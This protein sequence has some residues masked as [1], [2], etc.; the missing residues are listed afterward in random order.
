MICQTK[1]LGE[2]CEIE[3]GRTPSRGNKKYWDIERQTNNVWLSIADL[4]NVNDKI[5]S[6]SKE[7]I[8]DK[9]AEVSKIVRKGT[10]LASF[11]LTLGRLAFAGKDLYTNEAIAA[12]T[13][14]NEK[15]ISKDYLYHY[16]TFFDWHGEVKGDV[17]IKGKTLNKA[18]L[19][20]IKILFP[21]LPEQHRIVGILDEVFDGVGKAKENTEKNLKNSRA[22]F[23]SYL[24]SI[25]APKESLGKL[26]DIA[27]GKLDANAAVKNGKY[28]FF[29]CSRD[30]FAID[31]FAFD[32]EAILLA[33]NNAVGDF[34]VKHY[35][36]K[37]NAYQRTYVITVNKEN[38]ILYRWLY[39]QLLDRLKEF[40]LKSVGTGTKF[41]KLGMIKDLQIFLP[42]LPEQKAIVARLDT[43]S[44]KTKKL[45]EIYRQKLCNL[46]ELKKS[47]LKS[48]FAGKY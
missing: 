34:N 17:K 47:V 32:C 46:E 9:G 19:K 45:E 41:L 43:L 28:P 36:G 26:V 3:L 2:I 10:L 37:F 39:F 33:G 4:L 38:K 22:V 15:E 14:K 1:K 21:P 24:N 40:K 27:T 16:L 8:S 35:S 12:L 42:T 18:K 5:V 48:A 30:V 11:K 25:R 44:D 20:E 7:Y 29:T 13:I 31:K 6:D 23:E